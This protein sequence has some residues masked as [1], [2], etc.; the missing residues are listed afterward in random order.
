MKNILVVACLSL[1]ATCLFA[2]APNELVEPPTFYSSNGSL[3]LLMTAKSKLISLDTYSPNSWVYEVCY[4]SDATNNVCPADSR[5]ASAYGGMRLQLQPGDH[6]KIR[7]INQLP[8]APPDAEHAQ[9]PMGEMLKDNPTN[10]HT[11]GLIVEP[12]QATQS[13]PTYGDFV[14]VLAYPK[15]KL[16]TMQMPG[17]DY[18]DQPLDYDIYIPTNH[19][20]GLFWIHP[21]VHG[22]ALNQISAGMAGIIT[23]GNVSGYVSR[24]AAT[25]GTSPLAGAFGT[26]IPTVRHLTLKD[27]QI[28]ADNTVFTQED[29][30][31]CD[32]DQSSQSPQNGFC[33]GADNT[34]EGGGDYTGGK[35]FFTVNGQIYPTITLSSGGEVWR[36]THASGSR[37]YALTIIDDVTGLA[38]P[39]QVLAIDGVT[40]N[41]SVGSQALSRAAGGKF[42][43]A[44]CNFSMPGNSA[45]PICATSLRMMPSSRIEIYVPTSP[46]GGSA[47]LLTRVYSTGGDD[48]PSANLAHIDLSSGL[49]KPA[50]GLNL[51][52]SANALLT[53]TGIL[54]APARIDGPGNTGSISLQ[55]VPK[56]LR[57]LPPG[58][59]TAL[60]EHLTAL[61][62][63][64]D[65]PSVPCTA[66]PPGHH[67]RIFFGVPKG[68]PDAFG[69]GYEEVDQR[70]RPVPGTFRD[71]T[72]FDHSVIDVCLPLAKGNN[73]VNE[74]WELMNTH[75]EDH[76]FHMHQ[77]KFRVVVSSTS[78]AAGALV[79]NIPV[80]HGSGDCDG[81][82][83][84]WRSG[85]CHVQ[86]VALS[87]PFS[88]V[89]DFVYHCHILE[90]EDGGMMAH[91]RVVPNP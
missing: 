65:V 10:L 90:H 19:P 9:G 32:A 62:A 41:S 21:H 84:N 76:N 56:L 58:E 55:N 66:L 91:I 13:N 43:P 72:E 8:P 31:F 39:F 82:V 16:P 45:Q 4:R 38:R 24:A 35:W 42:V 79:D 51:K 26:S 47:T 17:L 37:S 86:P 48:W 57:Q 71:I 80:L 44:S 64:S 89:G 33:P 87:I 2:A 53:N 30:E 67:R 61:S 73:A 50:V 78:G 20:A 14:Y 52:G 36:I 28:Y 75:D 49:S 29:P 46:Q 25:F 69:L 6:L 5:T 1:F 63:P 12:R 60:R 81:S 3:D 40:I 88:Q 34:G 85:A 54:G 27:M 83:D 59:S 70:G 74:P 11:H 22:L 68:D 77:T 18:T 23:I 15:G 7:F